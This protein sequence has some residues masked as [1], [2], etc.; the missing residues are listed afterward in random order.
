MAVPPE[1]LAG[2]AR[3]LAQHAGLE[4]PA[5]VVEARAT[6]RLSA[7]GIAPD[8]YVELIGS[9]RGAGELDELIELCDRIGVM[10]RGALSGIVGNAAGAEAQIGRLM[11]GAEAA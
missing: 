4:L 3:R 6:A 10:F 8:A 9:I 2:I 7:L 11:T 1:I 5:W